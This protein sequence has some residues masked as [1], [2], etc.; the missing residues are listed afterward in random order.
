MAVP[1]QFYAEPVSRPQIML[2]SPVYYGGVTQLSHIRSDYDTGFNALVYISL[3]NNKIHFIY[4]QPNFHCCN[5]WPSVIDGFHWFRKA[6]MTA[7]TLEVVSCHTNRV[8][9]TRLQVHRLQHS[10]WALDGVLKPLLVAAVDLVSTF[11]YATGNH[12]MDERIKILW[13]ERYQ[14][15]SLTQLP[16]D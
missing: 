11:W 4:C 2:K 9:R 6:N 3:P 15:L 8:L 5:D 10:Y 13:I 12:H 7:R 1:L 16:A 14:L